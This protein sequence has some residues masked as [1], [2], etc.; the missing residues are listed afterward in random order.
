[1][2]TSAT[3]LAAHVASKNPG[4][5]KGT[6]PKQTIPVLVLRLPKADDSDDTVVY[7]DEDI[8]PQKAVMPDIPDVPDDPGNTEP[9]DEQM[10]R[11]D[12]PKKG[13]KKRT[14]RVTRYVI[15][16]S[17]K[18]KPK[19]FKCTKCDNHYGTLKQ[20]NNHFRMNHQ[21]VRCN[22][23]GKICKTPSTL[24]QHAYSHTQ[25]EKYKCKYC[26]ETFT[27]KSYLKVHLIKHSDRAM[28]KCPIVNC[29]KKF[30]IRV[31]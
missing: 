3:R 1:M 5:L 13:N 15:R 9:R 4:V 2:T 14:F 31:N 30:N 29:N 8:E 11:Q 16:R 18:C 21:K 7:E 27:F 20:L 25:G 12:G 22:E 23:C 28:Q 17:K 10:N 6:T 26:Q 24:R 19:R